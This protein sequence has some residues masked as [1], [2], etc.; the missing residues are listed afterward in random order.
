MLALDT[1]ENPSAAD[2]REEE[3]EAAEDD[4]CCCASDLSL[5]I[6]ACTTAPDEEPNAP[7]AS[8]DA[9]L[10]AVAAEEWLAAFAS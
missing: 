8:S 9:A 1:A 7:N 10:G 3:V 6:T 5:L 4:A 2:E